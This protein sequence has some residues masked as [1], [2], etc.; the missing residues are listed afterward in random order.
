MGDDHRFEVIHE[1][2]ER[3]GDELSSRIARL[4]REI[5][6]LR[7]KLEVL[8]PRPKIHYRYNRCSA[9][10]TC[11][12]DRGHGPYAYISFRDEHGQ[13][14]KRYLGRHPKLPQGAIDKAAYREMERRLAKLRAERDQLW[15]QIG[16]ALALLESATRSGGV[17]ERSPYSR[18]P[19]DGQPTMIATRRPPQES[20]S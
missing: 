1:R 15:E 19:G 10:C 8:S 14:R 16:R 5:A 7:A 12:G 17:R 6:D 11:N 4:D 3:A 9:T 2:V 20:P 18:E 13:I